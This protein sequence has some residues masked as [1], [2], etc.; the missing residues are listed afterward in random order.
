M[1]DHD[2]LLVNLLDESFTPRDTRNYGLA[3]V[4]N[5][6]SISCC[7][8]DFKRNKF[9][10]FVRCMGETV[11]VQ[12]GHP[13]DKLSFRELFEAAHAAIPWLTN[14]FK[15]V[16]I[17]YDGQKATLVPALLFD[18]DSRDQYLK[19]NYNQEHNEMIG[20][21]H[22]MP[23]D[24]WQIFTV[25]QSVLEV[26]REF[27]PKT[28]VIHYSSLLIESVWINY[29][30]RINSPHLFLHVREPVFD[31][32]IF[33][34]RQMEYFNTFPFQNP[35]DV[36]YYLIF[37]LEQLNLNPESIPVVFMGN[38]EQGNELSELLR[39]Y[40]RHVV[41]AGRNEAYSYSYILNRIQ[42]QSFFPLFN[43]FSCG[44]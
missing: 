24:A 10:G 19:F 17:A 26:T 43:F 5:E 31:L 27:F 18:P 16:K 38:A 14:S 35:E 11:K 44:L 3:M 42:P 29:K 12:S 37:V 6:A 22:L 36:A 23:L 4:L 21:D 9:L 13:A 25:P 1:A 28:R 20:H 2:P 40:V 34:G 7:I 41:E 33:D 39:R 8:L 15:H 32:M 30:N